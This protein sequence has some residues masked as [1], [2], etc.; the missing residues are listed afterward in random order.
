M[1]TNLEQCFEQLH[2][3]GDMV[4]NQELGFALSALNS[5]MSLKAEPEALTTSAY[6][7]ISGYDQDF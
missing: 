1:L 3:Q 7:H 4:V 2:L 5:N 6:Q